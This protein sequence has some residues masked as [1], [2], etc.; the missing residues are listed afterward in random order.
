MR[1]VA[2][3]YT[4]VEILAQARAIVADETTM[5][6]TTEHLRVLLGLSDLLQNRMRVMC[7]ESIVAEREITALRREVTTLRTREAATQAEREVF[8]GELLAVLG[9]VVQLVSHSAATLHHP[10]SEAPL[11][12]ANVH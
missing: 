10:T 6:A 12:A 4:D 8:H 5:I 1:T 9:A 11:T 2:E 3:T 7:E